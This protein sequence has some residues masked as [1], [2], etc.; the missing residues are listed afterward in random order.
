MD[1]NELLQA[2]GEL[3]ENNQKQIDERFNQMQQYMDKRFDKVD[4]RLLKIEMN[5]ENE[6][7]PNI[8]KLVEGHM[9]NADKLEKLEVITEDIE[10]IKWK[11]NKVYDVTSQHSR[12]IEKLKK[13]K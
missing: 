8:Q 4:D 1:N 11:V 6:I 5:Q 12:D 9:Q 2:I 3:L 13:A 10:D 7:K